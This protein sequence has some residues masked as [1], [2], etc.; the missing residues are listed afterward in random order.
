VSQR[1][2]PK[3]APIRRALL[4]MRPIKEITDVADCHD[5]DVHRQIESLGLRRIYLTRT[6]RELIA[7]RRGLD[8]RMVP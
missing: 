1:P 8:R 7:D 4:E 5:R 2:H 6:E 3:A